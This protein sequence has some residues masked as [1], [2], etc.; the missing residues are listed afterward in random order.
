MKFKNNK[1]VFFTRMGFGIV[2]V[3]TT[4]YITITTTTQHTQLTQLITINY[5][6]NNNVT[7]R[8]YKEFHCHIIHHKVK[9]KIGSRIKN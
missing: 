1:N 9:K 3:S 7:G 4:Q 2:M 8:Y 6:A 5:A